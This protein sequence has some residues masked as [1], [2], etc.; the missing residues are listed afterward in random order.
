M[1][2]QQAAFRTELC[3]ATAGSYYVEI[4]SLPA[5]SLVHTTARHELAGG[6]VREAEHW[7]LRQVRQGQQATNRKGNGQEEA[8]A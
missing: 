4:Y 5:D 7:V 6:A 3:T 8:A 2:K 1:N